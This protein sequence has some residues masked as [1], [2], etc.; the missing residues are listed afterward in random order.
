MTQKTKK[1]PN[2][3]V[4]YVVPADPAVPYPRI[5]G[6]EPCREKPEDWFPRKGEHGGAAQ[7]LC[8]TSCPVVWDCLR[9]ALANPQ[10]TAEGIWGGKTRGQRT[11][12]RRREARAAA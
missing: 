10:L 8:K 5:T 11:A 3:V 6:R 12:Q 7:T 9:W 4:P 1:K 2:P